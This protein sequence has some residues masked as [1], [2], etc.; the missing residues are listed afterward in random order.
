MKILLAKGFVVVKNYV[1][2]NKVYAR[3]FSPCITREQFV[4]EELERIC[5]S[6][7]FDN[8]KGTMGLMTGL[9]DMKAGKS[10]QEKDLEELR[11]FLDRKRAELNTEK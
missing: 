1:L 10:L 5:E 9:L 4:M 11:L 7:F 6:T 8:R 2:I 3:T